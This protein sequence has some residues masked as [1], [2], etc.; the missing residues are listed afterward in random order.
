MPKKPSYEDLQQK[1]KS[2]EKQVIE[3]KETTAGLHDSEQYYRDLYENAPIAYFAI[4]PKNGSILRFNSEAVRLLGY[5][6]EAF[7]QMSVL[8]LYADT[9]H[10][11][12]KARALFE[13]F[14]TG[15]PVRNEELQMKHRD[16][17][18]VWV[19]LNIE[20]VKSNIGQVVESRSMVIDISKRKQAEEALRESEEKFRALAE[21]APA[22]IIIAAGED[23]I[24]VN[25]AFESITGFTREEAMGMQFWE[26]VH[27]D[28]QKLVKKRGLARLQG[29][30]VPSHY[31]VKA[32][33][34]DGREIWFDMAAAS[35]NYGGQTATLAMAYDI[36]ETKQAKDSLLLREQ[37]LKDKAH[38][39][40]EMNAALRVL[41]NKR[42]DDKIEIEEKI[43]L[44]VKELI[45]PYLDNLKDTP[46]TTRQTTLLGIIAT[47]LAEIISPFAHNFASI[48]YRF[49]PQEIKIASLIRQGKKTKDIAELMS[50]STRTIEFHRTK[51]R[52]KIGLQ[53][54]KDSL[55]SHLLSLSNF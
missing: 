7:A 17:Q 34:K 15:E 1:V 51:I 46:L 20:P 23:F 19:S 10:G 52:E 45:Q 54:Q 47:N 40:E 38:D 55:Q 37:E 14:Q 33:I 11:V 31:E 35:F 39:L 16:G 4:G 50:L 41:L 5:K 18:P 8:D 44:N 42:D 13:R 26:I 53:S 22:I 21:S 25:S 9:A 36:T 48:K 29:K 27:P 6:K 28:M 49:T 30:T 3:C 32:L 2:L 24:Y 43:Q 12:S